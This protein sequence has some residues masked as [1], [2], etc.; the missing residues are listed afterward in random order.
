LV[1]PVRAPAQQA[2]SRLPASAAQIVDS[3]IR[4]GRIDRRVATDLDSATGQPVRALVVTT[5]QARREASFDTQQASL[6]SEKSELAQIPGVRINQLLPSL[7][8]TAIEISSPTALAALAA[9][10]DA[11]VMADEL[12]QRSDYQ[13]QQVIEAPVLRSFGYD[14]AGTYVGVIDSGVD[15]SHPD[16]GSCTT[17]GAPPPCRVAILAPDFS[18]NA[19]GSVYNDGMLDDDVRHGTNVAAIA[20]STAPGTRIIAADV[21]GEDGAYASDIAA[22]IQ[23]MINLKSAGYPIAA[24]NM[25]FGADQNTCVD[26]LGVSALANA[27]IVAV[28]AAGNSAYDTGSFVAGLANPACVPGVVS[29]GATFDTYAFNIPYGNCT[30]TVPGYGNPRPDDIACFSQA[31]SNLSILAPGTYMS[32]GGVTMS[33]TSQ[34][35]PH[36]AGAIA[37]LSAAVPGATVTDLV[38]GVRT[39]GVR[40]F[41]RRIALSFPRLSL[42]DALVATQSRVPGASGPESF[43]RATVLTGPN[44][45][46]SAVAGFR[47]QNGEPAHGGRTGISST[48]FAWTAPSDGQAIFSTTGSS[49]DT[50]MSIYEGTAL[51]DLRE[52]GSN[53]DSSASATS[54]EIG[55]MEVRSGVS[56]RIAVSCGITSTSCGAVSL[57]WRLLTESTPPENDSHTHATQLVGSSGSIRARNVFAT[58]QP[59]EPDQAGGAKAQ[60]SIWYKISIAGMNTASFNTAGTNFDTTLAVYEGSDFDALRPLASHNDDGALGAKFATTSRVTITT[61]RSPTT[62]WI[63]VDS[64]TGQTGTLNLNWSSTPVGAASTTSVSP[65]RRVAPVRVPTTSPEGERSAALQAGY[66]ANIERP[67]ADRMPNDESTA[68]LFD[69][70][71]GA[72]IGNGQCWLLVAPASTIRAYGSGYISVIGADGGLWSLTMPLLGNGVTVGNFENLDG[73]Q[74]NFAGISSSCNDSRSNVKVTRADRDALGTL[75]AVDLT[76]EHSCNSVWPSVKGQV[77]LR[78]YLAPEDPNCVAPAGSPVVVIDQRQA[79]HPEL[80]MSCQIFTEPAHTFDKGYGYDGVSAAMFPTPTSSTYI[81]VSAK[82]GM[83]LGIGTFPIIYDSLLPGVEIVGPCYQ[84]NVSGQV[85]ITKLTRDAEGIITSIAMTYECTTDFGIDRGVLRL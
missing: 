2:A 3:A 32:A 81:S 77:R 65:G 10:P 6:A 17:P 33:G 26:I 84:R 68:V 82:N 8:T 20:A 72:A 34:A 58:S 71:P 47:A 69:S 62:Y 46:V 44:G 21:F 1:V 79:I 63:S 24:V 54:A 22:A 9:L 23:Y 35:A 55:P 45:S 49:F 25:S 80:S 48:W 4:S 43:D 73:S 61:P 66:S 39:S 13:A 64:P 5:P 42:P 31:S 76:F 30:S 50:A 40:V 29:V 56:Y 51:N 60:K 57:Q 15:Y 85:S 38:D 27:G 16:L 53:D 18:R 74:F 7:N 70:P 36:V 19:D 14:G 52:V 75:V 41:D 37:A 78:P 83:H 11:T 67:C 59:N 12:L 28:A